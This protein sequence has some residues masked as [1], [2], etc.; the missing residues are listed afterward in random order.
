MNESSLKGYKQMSVIERNQQK[1][2]RLYLSYS[3]CDPDRKCPPVTSHH[4]FHIHLINFIKK[5]I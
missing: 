3:T 2:Y 4:W 5:Y 1:K